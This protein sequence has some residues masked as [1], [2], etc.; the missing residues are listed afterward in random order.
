VEDSPNVLSERRA[1]SKFGGRPLGKGGSI[2]R[3]QGENKPKGVTYRAGGAAPQENKGFGKIGEKESRPLTSSCDGVGGVAKKG[4]ELNAMSKEA[5]GESKRADD[6]RPSE[7]PEFKGERGW[8]HGC[9]AHHETNSAA[10]G[11]R[12]EGDRRRG[13]ALVS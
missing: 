9:E 2:P 6:S 8:G 11:P 1:R 12:G 7:R 10:G 3:K 4:E 13:K 5:R